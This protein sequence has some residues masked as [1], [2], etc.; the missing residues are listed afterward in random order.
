MKKYIDL[1][2]MCYSKFIKISFYDLS[3]YNIIFRYTSFLIT[4]I[5]LLC[6]ITA[7]LATVIR[8]IFT[9][10]GIFFVFKNKFLLGIS[11]YFFGNILDCVDGNIAR[12]TD[13][14]TYWGKFIDGFVDTV[15]ESLLFL[16]FYS[17]YQ[18]LSLG[19][20]ISLNFLF[21][22]TML[23]NLFFALIYEKF[24]N[25]QKWINLDIPKH[26]FSNQI[27]FSK[28]NKVT[29]NLLND[30]KYVSFSIIAIW[31]VSDEILYFLL[32]TSIFYSACPIY[33][34]FKFSYTNFKI[35]RKSKNENL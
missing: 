1:I 16:A 34:I 25:Y 35:Y 23:I 2:N 24:N 30:I 8:I 21:I 22:L 5:F 13:S 6:K 18:K 3:I 10:I 20:N 29:I 19:Q 11:F 15:V 17:A 12:A 14:A 32:A 26:K 31:G 33:L 28:A 4:P 27:N 9:L 7:N